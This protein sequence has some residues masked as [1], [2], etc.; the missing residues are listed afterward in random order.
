MLL[1]PN[2]KINV[3][4]DVLRRRADGYHDIET[5]M[6]PVAGLCDVLELTRAQTTEFVQTGALLDCAPEENLCMRACRLMEREYGIGGV[7]I[8]LHKVIPSGA[9]LGGGSADAAFVIKGLNTLFELGIDDGTLEKLA[10]ELGSDTAFFVRNRPAVAT[11]RGEILIPAENPFAGRHIIMVKPDIHISTREAYAGVVPH[12]PEQKLRENAFE[13]HLF[14]SHPELARIKQELLDHGA[15]YA[16]M[17]GSGSAIYGIFE[18][19]PQHTPSGTVYSGA[20]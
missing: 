19:E 16:S 11:G 12:I 3:G 6:V 18:N 17:S 8:H 4:L 1:F 13:A 7:K 20:I 14:A 15:I 2:A 5:L 10:A 9:G